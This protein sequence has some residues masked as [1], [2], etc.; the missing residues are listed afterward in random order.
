MVYGVLLWSLWDKTHVL[1][2]L[3]ALVNFWIRLPDNA[4]S[5]GFHSAQLTTQQMFIHVK[6]LT[7]QTTLITQPVQFNHSRTSRLLCRFSCDITITLNVSTG[8]VERQH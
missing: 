6:M 2:H 4:S 5:T 7:S 8:Y 1:S 3:S